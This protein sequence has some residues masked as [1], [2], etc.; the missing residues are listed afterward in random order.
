M[1][2]GYWPLAVP[3]AISSSQ[4]VANPQEVP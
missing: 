1:F 3:Q 2:G 4:L